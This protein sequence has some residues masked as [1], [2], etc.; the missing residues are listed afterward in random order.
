MQAGRKELTGILV[1]HL[2]T[3]VGL[4]GRDWGES[5]GSKTRQ[6]L[7]RFSVEPAGS[8]FAVTCATLLEERVIFCIFYD[9]SIYRVINLA[10][11]GIQIQKQLLRSGPGNQP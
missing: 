10:M 4:V 3:T 8:G 11:L 7:S 2:S 6:R 1:K 5:L 9:Y